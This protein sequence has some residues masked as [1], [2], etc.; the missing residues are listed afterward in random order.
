MLLELCLE[1]GEG[2]SLLLTPEAAG[3]S[4]GPISLCDSI[5]VEYL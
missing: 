4:R 3:V 2:E 5:A 1:L